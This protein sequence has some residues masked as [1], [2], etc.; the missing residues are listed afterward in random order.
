MPQGCSEL[1]LQAEVRIADEVVTIL[2]EA[3]LENEQID[4][5]M[6]A[7]G[8]EVSKSVH[9][10]RSQSARQGIFAGTSKTKVRYL[11]SRLTWNMA[12][13]AEK[14]IRTRAAWNAWHIIE[15][16][17]ESKRKFQVQVQRLQGNGGALF[18]GPRASAGQKRTLHRERAASAGWRGVPEQACEA[19]P[20]IDEPK[21]RQASLH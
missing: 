18:S 17:L 14:E 19:P 9:M 10:G 13:A 3:G 7:M 11:G 4:K 16:V 21:K 15:A 12:F 2:A 8:T 5:A 6:E 1:P 20:C